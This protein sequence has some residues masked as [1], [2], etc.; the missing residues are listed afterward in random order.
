MVVAA[1]QFSDV[2]WGSAETG[3]GYRVP[4]ASSPQVTK[5]PV[6]SGSG[7]HPDRTGGTR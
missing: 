3:F 6:R 1:R 4:V 5:G 2:R 7:Y